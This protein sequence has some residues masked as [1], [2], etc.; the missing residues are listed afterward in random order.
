MKDSSKTINSTE[1]AH[2][3]VIDTLSMET[4]TKEERLM[5]HFPGKTVTIINTSTLA[6]LMNKVCFQA[7]VQIIK[8]RKVN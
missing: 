4:S 7:K 1:W 5:V 2:K 8:Q 6:I 3:K